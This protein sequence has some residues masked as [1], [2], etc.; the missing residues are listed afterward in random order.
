MGNTSFIR[1]KKERDYTVINNTV[2]KDERLSWKAKGVFCY[3]LS[4]PEDWVIYQNELLKH[5]TDGRESLRNA[6]NE[7]E[8]Y[9]YLIIDK[10]RDEKGHFT[11]IYKIIE[12]PNEK[13]ESE[14]TE[15]ENPTQENRHGKTESENPTQENRHGKTESEN[16]TLL[17]TNKQ[18]T[19]KQNTNELNTN[20]NEKSKRFTIPTLEE[21][22]NYCNERQNKINP[23]YFLDYYTARDWKFNNGGK[24]KDWKATI[25]NW[26]RLEKNREQQNKKSVFDENKLTFD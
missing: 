26:E 13:T 21:I 9:G 11:A 6:I 16:P 4:L 7:L 20:E 24:M 19:N 8:E 10:K 14:K 18:N 5:S 17:N 25:R 23:E 3:L 12:N 1:E 2:L 15:S 22:Q